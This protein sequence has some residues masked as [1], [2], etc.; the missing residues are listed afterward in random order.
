MEELVA[1]FQL[2]QDFAGKSQLYETKRF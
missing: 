1:D 2:E